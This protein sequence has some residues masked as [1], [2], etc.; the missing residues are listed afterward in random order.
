M[1]GALRGPRGAARGGATTRARRRGGRAH[2][3]RARARRRSP[4]GWRRRWARPFGSASRAGT[5]STATSRTWGRTGCWCGR[6]RTATRCWCPLAAVVT[7]RSLGRAVDR[8]PR[9]RRFGLGYALRALSRDRATV[10]WRWWATARGCWGPSTPWAPTTS[11]SPS[12][13]R[14]SLAAAR[15]SRP[16][17]RCR[18]RRCGGGVTTLTRADKR[19]RPRESL[20]RPVPVVRMR[21]GVGLVAVGHRRV[22][23]RSRVSAYIRWMYASSSTVSTRHWPRPPTLIAGQV[24]RCGP[25]R[26]PGPRTCR[27]SRTPR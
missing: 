10:V 26:R 25:V 13:P 15:T 9:R 23:T 12:T 18:S 7:L 4:P 3:A 14:G 11:T 6:A 27:G 5:G 16:W 20:S 22:V 1:G 8:R 17:R 2:P 21:S 19:G 24:T